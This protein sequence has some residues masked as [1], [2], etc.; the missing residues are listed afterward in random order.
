MKYSIVKRVIYTLVSL[1]VGIF[2][3]FQFLAGEYGF[4]VGLFFALL[5]FIFYEIP[6]EDFFEEKE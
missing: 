4:L 6:K 2:A 5:C 3:M 1:G